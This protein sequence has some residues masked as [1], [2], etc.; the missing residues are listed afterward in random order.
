MRKG[1]GQRWTL[2]RFERD[3]PRKSIGSAEES[4]VGM[5]EPRILPGK[6]MKQSKIQGI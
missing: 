4:E 6:Y 5:V 2:K 1:F 3:S